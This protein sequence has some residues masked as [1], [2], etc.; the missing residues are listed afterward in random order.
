MSFPLDSEE[1]EFV[2]ERGGLQ[3]LK[4]LLHQKMDEWSKAYSE[5]LPPG[6][7]VQFDETLAAA[8]LP[9]VAE[10][11]D[12]KDPADLESIY[13]RIVKNSNKSCIEYILYWNFQLFPT[14]SYDYEP[15]YIYLADD[16]VERVAFDLMHYKARVRLA[17]SAFKIWGLWHGFLSTE[18]LPSKTVD[19][20][21]MRLDNAILGKWYN[22]NPKAKFEIKQK[23]TDPWLLRDWSTFRDERVLPS[24][25]GLFI[26]TTENRDTIESD[27][28]L[29]GTI[30][31]ESLESAVR[32][33]NRFYH[34][35]P[36]ILKIRRSISKN[37]ITKETLAA[38]DSHVSEVRGEIVNEFRRAGY[39]KIINGRATWTT[40]G[41]AIRGLLM[42]NLDL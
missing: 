3:W 22:R 15:I 11:T 29:Q 17:T 38:V 4:H 39:V 31:K 6:Y 19:R 27:E 18:Q 32:D 1:T 5:I 21:L 41:Q 9:K 13:Y 10:Y 16:S 42:S 8:H 36:D 35:G 2:N 23:L 34:R 7:Q 14:H 26:M 12:S 30:N 40:K 20:P 37:Q 24:A 28:S 25:K 33:I